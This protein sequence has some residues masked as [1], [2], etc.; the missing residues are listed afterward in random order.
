[1]EFR[2]SEHPGVAQEDSPPLRYVGLLYRS[3]HSNTCKRMLPA[4]TGSTSCK[5]PSPAT[6]AS[7]PDNERTTQAGV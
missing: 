6:T 3:V 5:E 2:C 1:M 7:P 4:T